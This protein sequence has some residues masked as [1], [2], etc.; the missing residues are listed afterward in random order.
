MLAASAIGLVA[1]RRW[2]RAVDGADFDG[3]GQVRAQQPDEKKLPVR[4]DAPTGGQ[5]LAQMRFR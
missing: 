5:V 4:M 1:Y 2:R 3:A